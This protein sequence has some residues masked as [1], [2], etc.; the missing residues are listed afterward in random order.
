MG[1][2]LEFATH[3]EPTPVVDFER[4]L[5][6]A[7]VDEP[8]TTFVDVGSGLGRGV[9]LA[10]RRPFRQVVGIELSGA[11]HEVAREN[12]A[13]A[14][15]PLRR[16]R[17]IRLVRADATTFA[18]PPGPLLL[19][20]YNPF[21]AEVMEPMLRRV[22]GGEPRGV[23]LAYHTPLERETVTAAGFRLHA[24]LGFGAVFRSPA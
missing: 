22:L 15:D 20:L 18:F 13:Q 4:L 6:A 17:D 3:Y 24:D 16:C 14:H 21:R 12:L 2:N 9:L 11:L 23:T 10:A 7:G 8:S 1:D 19:Y 5:D